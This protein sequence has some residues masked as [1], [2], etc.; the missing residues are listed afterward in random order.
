[1]E[2]KQVLPWLEDPKN[3]GSVLLEFIKL[4]MRSVIKESFE[5]IKA[6]ASRSDQMATL[7]AAPWYQ[8]SRLIRNQLS[9]EGRFRFSRYDRSVLPVSW[10]HVT[11]DATLEGAPLAFDFFSPED[12]LALVF[13]MGQFVEARFI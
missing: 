8:F 2:L 13:E 6:Y 4:Q 9:H 7:G 12:G 10:R 11:I 5:H 3:G 1:M